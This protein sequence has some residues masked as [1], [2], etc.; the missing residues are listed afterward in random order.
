MACSQVQAVPAGQK[1]KKKNSGCGNVPFH[2]EARGPAPPRSA[3]V[4]LAVVAAG[5]EANRIPCPVAASFRRSRCGTPAHRHHPRP[6]TTPP[7]R[8]VGAP[9]YDPELKGLWPLERTTF[10]GKTAKDGP[11]WLKQIPSL[12]NHRAP[13]GTL[14]T[15]LSRKTDLQM[16]ISAFV[17]A[18]AGNRPSSGPYARHLGRRAAERRRETGS[19][20]VLSSDEASSAFATENV[21]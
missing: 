12:P 10:S 17:S 5:R 7:T 9:G 3:P 21:I 18:F 6:I 1:K 11:P 20:A 14:Q 2:R 13:V 16:I 4:R 19:P 15:S 8:S